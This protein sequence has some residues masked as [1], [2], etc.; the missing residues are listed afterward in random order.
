M[1][2]IFGVYIQKEHE[3]VDQQLLDNS[4]KLLTHRGPDFQRSMLLSDHVGLAHARLSI[5]DLS[6]DAHQPFDYKHLSLTYNGEIFNYLELREELQK[7]NYKFYTESDT[8]VLL[9]SYYH[10]GPEAVNKFNGMWAFAIYDSKNDQIFCSRDRFGIKP[11]NYTFHNGRFIFASEIKSI[12]SYEPKLKQPNYNSIANYCRES[13]GAQ[14]PETWFENIY[15]LAPASNMLVSRDGHKIEKYWYYPQSQSS[16]I[17]MQEALKQY[18]NL[19]ED[20][21]KLRM[22]SDVPVGATLSSGLDSSA[23]VSLVDKFYNNSLNTYTASFPTEPFDEFKI[24][25]RF[26]DGLNLTPNQV[27]VKYDNYID[28]LKKLI[29]HL[30]SGHSSP[31]I[32]PLF[33]V[34]QRAKEDITVFLEGQGAD[35]S[36]A[37]YIDIVILDYFVELIQ[38]GSWT[39][40]FRE[41]Y[42]YTKH[43]SLSNAVALFLRTNASPYIRKVLRK[44]LNVEKVYSGP[45]KNFDPTY[46]DDTPGGSKLSKKLI[47]QHKTGLVNLLHYGD[48]ISMMHSLENRLPFLDYRLVE[49]V[50]K[51]PSSFKI[52][53]G[54]GKHIHRL[55]F[56]DILPNYIINNPLK[57]GFKS[58]LKELFKPHSSEG[59]YNIISGNSISERG[60]FNNNELSKLISKH[61]SGKYDYSRLLFRLLCVELWFQVFIDPK[62]AS[63]ENSD[64]PKQTAAL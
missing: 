62:P 23:I 30:E 48:A 55:A 51:L 36:L 11:F 19:F 53:N 6:A 46:S 20:A 3:K 35:E 28:L 29:Y 57:L 44:F 63:N 61:S 17:S 60:L 54:L 37:G 13:V 26:A 15:R 24:V 52:N 1:C 42:A 16:S 8:E 41:L 22:R 45:L 27:V 59:V 32:F 40:A 12:L 58:P 31:A 4:I 38:A 49:F 18:Q 21:V 50:F 56:S 10:W 14:S 34:T 9:K 43:G 39:K 2:G 5:I 64:T 25:D 7:L 33:K 47:E